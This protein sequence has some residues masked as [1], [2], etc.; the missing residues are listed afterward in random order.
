MHSLLDHTNIT[1]K[2]IISFC[3]SSRTFKSVMKS[4]GFTIGTFHF[5]SPPLPN[6]RRHNL[7]ISRRAL[8][9]SDILTIIFEV[10]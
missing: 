8:S 7:I 4:Y 2:I 3:H 10:Q 5:L 6:Y 9:E 1:N